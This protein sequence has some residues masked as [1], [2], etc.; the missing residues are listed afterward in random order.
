M[1]EP[2]TRQFTACD[3]AHPETAKTRGK[4]VKV[5]YFSTLTPFDILK[6][7]LTKPTDA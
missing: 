3:P 1:K 6:L 4:S 7:S 2:L 5:G